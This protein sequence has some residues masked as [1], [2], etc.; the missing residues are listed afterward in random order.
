MTEAGGINSVS[1]TTLRQNL[2]ATPTL[3]AWVSANAGSGKTHVLARRVI[4]LLLRGAR[5]SAIL[6]LTYTK[7]AS[8]EMSNRVFKTLGEWVRLD[9]AALSQKITELEGAAVEPHQLILARRLFATAL[10]TPGGLKIQTIHAFCEAVLHRFPLEA[11]IPGHFSVLDDQKAAELLA[12][13]R[14]QLMSAQSFEED[15]DLAAAVTAALDLGGEAGFDKLLSGLYAR[16]RDYLAFD[17]RARATGGAESMIRSALG[18][19]ADET[20]ASAIARSWPLDALPVDYVRT[21]HSFAE[22]AKS[23]TRAQNLAYGVLAAGSEPDP[24]HRLDLLRQVFL[25]K[26]GE[27][28]KLGGVASKT[29]AERFP[30]V[31]ERV[32]QAQAQILYV[33]DRL[34]RLTA[35]EA[36][37]TAF[38][39]ARRY[40]GGFESLKTRQA[41]LDYDDLIAATE[42]LL[43]RSGASAWVHY[44]LDQGIDHVLVDEA[45]DTAPLQWSVIGALSD[46][47]FAGEG[48]RPAL[49]TI[50]AVGDE[51]Q[52]IYSFQGARPERFAEERKRIARRA[53]DA[54]VQFEQVSLR[55]SFRSSIEVLKLVDYV[56]ADADARRGMG[57]DGEAVIHETARMQAPGLV[58]IWPMIAKEKTD[59]DEDWTAAFDEVPET[60]PAARLAR[61]ITGLLR[62]WVG[63]ETIEDQ[64]SGKLRPVAPGDILIL[65]RKRDGFV[66]TLLRTL[67][68]TTDIP[69]A[70]AD[71]LRLTDHIAVQDLMALG[72]FAVLPE[73]DLSLA[74]LIKSPLLGLDED[75]L[76]RLAA[77]RPEGMSVWRMLGELAESDPPFAAVLQ[78]LT[79]WVAQAEALPP[80]DFFAALLGPEGGRRAYLA[81]L[82]HEVGDV[83]DEFLGLALDHEQAG[84][85]GL[86]SF[87]AMLETDAPEIKREM[88]GQSGAVRIMTVH[89]A[90]GL[91]APIVFLVDSGGEAFQHTHQPRL[92][93]LPPSPETSE[94]PTVPVWLPDKTYENGATAPMRE[95]M[96]DQ[97]E[98]EY[99]RLLYVG[100][101]RA[102]DRLVV[103]GYRG[104]REVKTP[105]WH[106]LAA[107]GIAAAAADQGYS[108][109]D[110]VHDFGGEPFEIRRLC[111]SGAENQSATET[112][113]PKQDT[114]PADVALDVA[115]APLP[116]PR[117]LPRPLAPSGV[118]AVLEDSGGIASR[119]PFADT[120]AGSAAALERGTMMHRLLQALPSVPAEDRRAMLSR[121]LAR[122]LPADQA[123]AAAGI[124]A[125]VLAVLEDPRF[126]PIFEADGEAEVSVMGPLRIGGEERAVSG[127]I[128]RVALDGDRLL[129]VD[130]KTGLAPGPGEQP[131]AGHVSQLAIYRALLAPLYPGRQIDAALVYLSGPNLVEIAGAALDDAFTRLAAPEGPEYHGSMSG[132]EKP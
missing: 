105:T 113:K 119:S 34:A 65:V 15:P 24:A 81:R 100:L 56:F 18:L 31:A 48:S 49:R 10:E 22:S 90:K 61:R 27:P 98:E 106:S 103:C 96:R 50:F 117:R 74:A 12:E 87:L 86:Q 16:R 77:L 11:N 39:L 67:K 35:L 112:I 131:P 62:Q 30:D 80:H 84:L 29:V 70:G 97:A 33:L 75:D 120:G 41:L 28:A 60:A 85:P 82:G 73:D 63:R 45:Q 123:V 14:R 7:A 89:A 54:V 51:K 69:V 71:R 128:D 42:A 55:V 115:T 3:S 107:A 72:R 127:R 93:L 116:K 88:E 132:L 26:A 58:E 79:R 91:E 44:K 19:E 2:A 37:L 109:T 38:R 59:G 57:A 124:E 111:R 43:S 94:A 25:T 20:E 92:W 23:A 95:K 21:L 83:L 32:D 13:A 108:V 8:A 46:E 76:F 110:A 53:R 125:Q 78:K 1:D 66:P 17:A 52:S 130:Y 68:A 9:D 36:S 99:R 4:R 101:T 114:N 5:P 122:A 64:K 129:I 6:C 102:A 118:S 40:L 104:L 47:F 126:S 121:Y